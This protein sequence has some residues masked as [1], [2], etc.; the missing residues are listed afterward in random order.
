M[1]RPVG[2]NLRQTRLPLSLSL[3]LPAGR[4]NRTTARAVRP[5]EH[6]YF[7][8]T[9]PMIAVKKEEE[10]EETWSVVIVLWPAAAAAEAKSVIRTVHRWFLIV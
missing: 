3:S 5:S 10:E 2:H 9:R 6:F 1:K 7:F 4:S 8:I